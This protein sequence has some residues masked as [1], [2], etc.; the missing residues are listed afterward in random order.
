MVM[1]VDHSASCQKTGEESRK[2]GWLP[3]DRRERASCQ[4]ARLRALLFERT[5]SNPCLPHLD[6]LP[7]VRPL[8]RTKVST[9]VNSAQLEKCKV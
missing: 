5:S 9:E 1:T 6:K 3:T 2:E 7:P 4:A 8:E